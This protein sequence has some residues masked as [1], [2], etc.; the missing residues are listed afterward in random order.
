[1]NTLNFCMRHTRVGQLQE[2]E[3]VLYSETLVILM[4]SCKVWCILVASL[5]LLRN[6]GNIKQC[7]FDFVDCSTMLELYTAH[8][9]HLGKVCLVLVADWH[10][11]ASPFYLEVFFNLEHAGKGSALQF[12]LGS[13]S[14]H[15]YAG[16][17]LPWRYKTPEKLRH[18]CDP[19]LQDSWPGKN[20]MMHRGYQLGIGGLKCYNPET[21]F[22]KS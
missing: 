10:A 3:F 4:A 7:V 12:N 8:E 5:A 16:S 11:Q 20:L 13:K 1:M 14:H 22:Y 9:I 6:K 21:S 19:L 17:L 18:F 2:W 15:H